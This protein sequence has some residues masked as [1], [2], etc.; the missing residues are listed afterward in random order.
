MNDSYKPGS[1]GHLNC[2]TGAGT[3]SCRQVQVSVPTPKHNSALTVHVAPIHPAITWGRYDGIAFAIDGM[4]T[5]SG[6]LSLL[7]C[8]QEGSE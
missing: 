5:L 6:R 2:N 8:L 4:D 7:L 1:Q 3:S